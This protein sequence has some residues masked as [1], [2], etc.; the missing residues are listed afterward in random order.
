M[1][2]PKEIN[3]ELRRAVA[4]HPTWPT[5][6]VHAVNKLIEEAG[7]TARAVDQ[8]VYEG[9]SIGEVRKEAIQTGAMVLRFLISL[10]RY[11]W[12]GSEQHVQEEGTQC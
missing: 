8:A 7:E 11:E 10:D 12:E 1:Y 3:E 2:W 4:K 5:D 6:P 9:G